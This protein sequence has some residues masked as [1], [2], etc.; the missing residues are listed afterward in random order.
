VSPLPSSGWQTFQEPDTLPSEKNMPTGPLSIAHSIVQPIPNFLPIDFSNVYMQYF[1]HNLRL[2]LDGV[3]KCERVAQD[4]TY[5]ALILLHL[6]TPFNNCSYFV[7]RRRPTFTTTVNTT[8]T[9]SRGKVRSSVNAKATLGAWPS[10]AR[11][12]QVGRRRIGDVS[13]GDSY[14]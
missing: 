6:Q 11:R 8:A 12:R 10:S 2:R 13:L 3:A 1:V 7:A 4:F 14:F 5:K 9:E